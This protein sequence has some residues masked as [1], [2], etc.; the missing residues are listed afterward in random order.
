MA[1]VWFMNMG[2]VSNN[3]AERLFDL[4]TAKPLNICIINTVNGSE[5]V[6]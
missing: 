6:N 3:D 2:L 4:I 1:G 5:E